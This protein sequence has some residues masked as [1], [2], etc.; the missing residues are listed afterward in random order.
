MIHTAEL[1]IDFQR[2]VREILILLV[3][4]SEGLF[5][6]HVN[7]VD[8]QF[9]VT[10][11]LFVIISRHNVNKVRSDYLDAWINKII[12]IFQKHEDK[13]WFGTLGQLILEDLS[14]RV[15]RT[16]PFR[17][18][19]KTRQIGDGQKGW[20]PTRKGDPTLV[21]FR[22]K[23]FDKTFQSHILR[24]LD[25]IS[26][27]PH[28]EDPPARNGRPAMELDIENVPATIP[29][30]SLPGS[31]AETRGRKLATRNIGE[32]VVNRNAKSWNWGL[33]GVDAQGR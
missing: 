18:V 4:R 22:G 24:A 6:L 8:P 19:A 15:Q 23:T 13:A 3:G 9:D 30:P 2:N 7:G 5:E 1:R 31:V 14:N 10:N 12:P 32:F 27:I 28:N 11:S 20:H 21:Q 16:R 33:S 29:G 17:I 26:S 25:H